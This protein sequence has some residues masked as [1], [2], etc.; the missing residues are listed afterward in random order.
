MQSGHEDTLEERY[1]IKCCF[2]LG[3]NATETYGMLQTA[4]GSSCMNGA[5]VCEWH[6]RFKEGRESVRDDE[7]CGRSKEVRTPE[8]IGQIKIFMHK[9][10]RVSIETISAQFDVSVGTVHTIIHEELKMWKICAKF[11]PRVLREDQKE[12]RWH[13][14]R[15]IVELINSD[16]AV[17]DA[18]L[19]CDESWIYCYDPE[20]KR[21]SS[22]WK[23]AGSPRPKK[24]R[25]S[26]ST[27]KLLMI[28]F[29]D[30]TGMIYMHW[31]PTGQT[32][33][34]EYYVEVL[35]E[36][37][38]R[39]RRKRPAL[40]KSG[41]WHF[42]QD[43]APVHNSILVTDY[44]TKMGIKTV[45]QPPY[46][47]DLAPCDFWLFPKLKEKLRGCRYETIEEMKEAVTKVIDKRIS[48]EPPEVVGTVQVH[49]SRRRLLQRGLEFHMCTTNKSA[50]MKKVWK[51]IVCS[52]YL[53]KS[54][55]WKASLSSHHKCIW[56][57]LR[58]P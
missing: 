56:S 19:T 6:K 14:S 47:P 1:A 16:P 33:N 41:Q 22:Q 31:V 17:L 44:L 25:Q 10:R 39:F 20:T 52:L 18:L 36:F 49:C 3:K 15:K 55:C 57:L 38:K 54:E 40:F 24:A 28:L 5:S 7:R 50:H 51:L 48:M 2:K 32:V 34:K 8:L 27:H 46:C 29:F 21:Q 23:H 13:D 4:F 42:H 30:S 11:I 12:R 45:P 37:R 43:N 58:V 53:V 26:K 9:D 35:R